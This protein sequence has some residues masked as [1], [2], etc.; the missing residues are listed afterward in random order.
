M[1]QH[2]ISQLALSPIS[3]NLVSDFGKELYVAT[4]EGGRCL[5][6]A[7]YGK[8]TKEQLIIDPLTILGF[9]ALGTT[10]SRA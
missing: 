3:F 9:G 7:G 8:Q 1:L 6:G 5:P 2:T 10:Q 4:L